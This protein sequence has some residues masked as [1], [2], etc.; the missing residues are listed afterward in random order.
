MPMHLLSR[1]QSCAFFASDLRYNKIGPFLLEEFLRL[2][3]Q[4]DVLYVLSLKLSW[5][6]T[7]TSV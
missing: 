3:L 2:S 5:C 6:A 7:S 1:K 4:L